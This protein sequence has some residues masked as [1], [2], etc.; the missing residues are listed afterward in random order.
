MGNDEREQLLVIDVEY[1]EPGQVYAFLK[2]L[3]AY[4][5]RIGKRVRVSLKD[6]AVEIKDVEENDA[7]IFQE[8]SPRMASAYGV[9]VGKVMYVGKGRPVRVIEPSLKGQVAQLEIEN[10]KL[11]EETESLQEGYEAS[12]VGLNEELGN[13]REARRRIAEIKRHQEKEIQR[14][15]TDN[16]RLLEDN[17]AL[18]KTLEK[19]S[20]AKTEPLDVALRGVMEQSASIR[21]YDEIFDKMFNEIDVM[22]A[23]DIVTAGKMTLLEYS[24][25]VL[26]AVNVTIANEDELDSLEADMPEWE[27]SEQAKT[28]LPVYLKA[29]EEL[30]FLLD[31][32]EGNV[33]VPKH[34]VP[35]ITGMINKEADEEAVKKYEMEKNTYE[36]KRKVSSDAKKIRTTHAKCKEFVQKVDEITQSNIPITYV[37][38]VGED[39]DSYTI[40]VFGPRGNPNSHVSSFVGY[41]ATKALRSAANADN[42]EVKGRG[43]ATEISVKLPKSSYGSDS[44]MQLQRKVSD[45]L[46]LLESDS[47]L[48]LLGFG[49]KAMS[50]EKY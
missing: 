19:L 11:H 21:N 48:G 50:I 24:N 6:K 26:S 17:K 14:L 12:I 33:G 29:Q 3:R 10:K 23:E 32:N 42:P 35:S 39:K 38:S 4:S 28:M 7:Q 31:L 15:N 36:M 18:F 9:K 46:R 20:T 2:D 16:Q 40:S 5:K 43:N 1:K 8:E 30:K 47:D 45:G 27:N 22:G 13:E 41:H 25:R 44:V 34:L 37:V 49:V